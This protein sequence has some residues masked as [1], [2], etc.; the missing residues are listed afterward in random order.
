MRGRTRS[1]HESDY[2]DSSE[3]GRRERRHLK[4]LGVQSSTGLALQWHVTR[5]DETGLIRTRT[6]TGAGKAVC[7]SC[8]HGYELLGSIRGQQV[9]E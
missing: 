1:T 7:G 5:L 9:F 3:D 8:E 4:D 2:A 6:G